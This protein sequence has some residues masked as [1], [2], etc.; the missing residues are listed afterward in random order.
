MIL[1]ST[2]NK[3]VNTTFGKQDLG[4]EYERRPV[5]GISQH[6]YTT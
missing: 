4:G 1:I 2:C 6:K 3:Y 5:G